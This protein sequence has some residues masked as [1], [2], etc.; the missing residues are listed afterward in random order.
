[1]WDSARRMSTFSSPDG[2]VRAS[3]CLIACANNWGSPCRGSLA[4]RR[5]WLAKLAIPRPPANPIVD[6]NVPCARWIH[7]TW[8]K[9]FIRAALPDRLALSA[10]WGFFMSRDGS[11][12]ASMGTW[13]R[14][15]IPEGLRERCHSGHLSSTR[16]VSGR[17]MRQAAWLGSD[18]CGDGVSVGCRG[19]QIGRARSCLAPGC[20]SDRL[21]SCPLRSVANRYPPQCRGRSVACAILWPSGRTR[22]H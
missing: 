4:K 21:R 2:D 18:W 15:R 10:A 1:M 6:S 22:R 11:A 12:Q 3:K 9:L 13:Q 7:R 20:P 14:T 16:L 19:S 8:G 17:A 5:N